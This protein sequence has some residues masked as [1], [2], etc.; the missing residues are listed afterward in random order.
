MKNLCYL[1]HRPSLRKSNDSFDT[2]SLT[3][4]TQGT[5][6]SLHFNYFSV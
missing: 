4:I 1:S 5:M 3:F 6:K 2:I